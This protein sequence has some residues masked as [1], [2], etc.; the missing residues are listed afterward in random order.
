LKKCSNCGSFLRDE[1]ERCGVCGNLYSKTTVEEVEKNPVE[2]ELAAAVRKARILLATGII[3]LG[4]AIAA[5]AESGFGSVLV[6]I[7]GIAS[8]AYAIWMIPNL[9]LGGYGKGSL[10][11]MR[12]LRARRRGHL[13]F[14]ADDKS[15]G[16]T[17]IHEEE[18]NEES[19][20]REERKEEDFD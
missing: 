5:I 17:K 18:R 11:R 9:L 1:D 14:P 6:F 2:K 8:L 7:I 4:F 20:V 16:K 15:D 3:A 13:L 10:T 12:E 19:E